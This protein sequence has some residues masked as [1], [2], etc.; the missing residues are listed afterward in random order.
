MSKIKCDQ[1]TVEVSNI[2]EINVLK[3]Y[4]ILFREPCVFTAHLR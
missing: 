4:D 2:L 1:G 3:H